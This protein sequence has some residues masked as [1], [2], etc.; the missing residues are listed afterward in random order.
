MTKVQKELN[1]SNIKID[2]SNT[3]IKDEMPHIITPKIKTK[4]PL[5]DCI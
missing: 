4:V 5:G 1:D 3:E 2:D